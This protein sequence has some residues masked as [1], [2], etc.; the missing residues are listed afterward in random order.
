M[1]GYMTALA[2]PFVVPRDRQ[3]SAFRRC[4]RRG[5]SNTARAMLF[6]PY[7]VDPSLDGSEVVVD[8]CL[9]GNSAL[10]QALL[11]DERVQ[12]DDWPKC[13]S[14]AMLRG[15]NHVTAVV[16]RHEK[17][18]PLACRRHASIFGWDDLI[19]EALDEKASPRFTVAIYRAYYK[20]ME[21]DCT[22]AERRE[23]DRRWAS[24]KADLEG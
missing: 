12:V 5:F 8:A 20:M 1:I 7:V 6:L 24:L 23:R 10:V 11:D 16:L 15:D 13:I 22:E 3:Q 19:A 18:N 14:T 9:C 2:A 21:N 4:V 17:T